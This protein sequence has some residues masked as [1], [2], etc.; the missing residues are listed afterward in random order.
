MTMSRV[1]GIKLWRLLEYS[2]DLYPPQTSP[3]S[4]SSGP[5]P[6][7]QMSSAIVLDN[8]NDTAMHDSDTPKIKQESEA[9]VIDSD[10][11]A[12]KEESDAGNKESDGGKK[13]N[14]DEDKRD[15]VLGAPRW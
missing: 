12:G 1:P 3:T 15:K 13:E 6:T 14:H 9:V 2:F 8:D 10:S 5:A 11:D 7:A 4:Q